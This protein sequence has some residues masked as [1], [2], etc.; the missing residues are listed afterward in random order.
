MLPKVVPVT[1]K[2]LSNVQSNT[3]ER[4]LH[5]A[6]NVAGWLTMNGHPLAVTYC[7]LAFPIREPSQ[8]LSGARNCFMA[9]RD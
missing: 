6:G 2:L 1:C 3:D 9:G 4:S 5:D 7:Q 8:Y